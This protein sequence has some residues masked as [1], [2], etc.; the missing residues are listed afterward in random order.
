MTRI[1]TN[2][3]RDLSTIKSQI[4]S[5]EAIQGELKNSDIKVIRL[6][7]SA[8][9]IDYI[10]L[11]PNEPDWHQKQQ[12]L[13]NCENPIDTLM[14]SG[15]NFLDVNDLASINHINEDNALLHLKNV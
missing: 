5:D 13:L 11:R 10:A 12:A 1:D 8:S 6:K 2:I 14:K 15:F 9:W 4:P 7:S 3:F